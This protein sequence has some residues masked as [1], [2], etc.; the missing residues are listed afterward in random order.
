VKTPIPTA[1][2]DGAAKR[3]LLLDDEEAIL[4]PMSRYFQKLGFVVDM[5]SEPEEADALI[6]HRQYDLAILDLRLTKF[7]DAAGLDVLREIRRR[8]HE[9]S[10]VILS[11]YASPEAEAE[12]WRLGADAVLKKPQ[13]LPDLAQLALALAGSPA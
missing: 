11:A 4:I 7:S 9:T 8:N 5:A 10:V 2:P 13:P 1:P 12:A 3:I 6:A